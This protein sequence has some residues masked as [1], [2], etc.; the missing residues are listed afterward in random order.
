MNRS[1]FVRGHT[2]SRWNP[3]ISEPSSAI[4]LKRGTT[5]SP[6]SIRFTRE[7]TG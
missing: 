2:Y 4:Q 3:T 5:M 1:D 7:S 6:A